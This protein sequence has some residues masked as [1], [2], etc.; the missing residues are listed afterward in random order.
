[1]KYKYRHGLTK[2][3]VLKERCTRR[4][5]LETASHICCRTKPARL[6]RESISLKLLSF[7]SFL[8]VLE[9]KRSKQTSLLSVS[10]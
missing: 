1:M 3:E 2:V 9:D 5:Y 10:Q 7:I 4:H 8:K 6:S